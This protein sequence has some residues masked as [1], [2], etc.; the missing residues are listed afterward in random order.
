ML[1]VETLRSAKDRLEDFRT[2]MRVLDEESHL[3]LNDECAASVR[4]ILE[5]RISQL[6]LDAAKRPQ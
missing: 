2:M 4:A 5:H 6:E 1:M 3:G